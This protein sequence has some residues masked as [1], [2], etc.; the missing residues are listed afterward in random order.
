MSAPALDVAHAELG[1]TFPTVPAPPPELPPPPLDPGGPLPPNAPNPSPVPPPPVPSSNS[2][3]V[4]VP[5][6]QMNAIVLTVATAVMARIFWGP[7]R[8]FGNGGDVESVAKVKRRE[9]SC[10]VHRAPR[11]PAHPAYT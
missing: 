9:V 1:S 7:S 10:E 11:I 8:S 3:S 6:A 2:E 5:Q 4:V